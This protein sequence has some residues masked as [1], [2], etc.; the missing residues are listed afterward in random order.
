MPSSALREFADEDDV[1]HQSEA[2][3]PAALSPYRIADRRSPAL[4]ERVPHAAHHSSDDGHYDDSDDE[5]DD[6]GGG[7]AVQREWGT[8][9]AR[10]GCAQTGDAQWARE[11]Q[12]GTARRDRGPV[13]DVRDAVP[14][15]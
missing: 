4:T 3:S 14:R 15:P 2:R 7:C 10:R 12:V 11:T 1:S 13:R 6:G 9:G 5:Y 8:A